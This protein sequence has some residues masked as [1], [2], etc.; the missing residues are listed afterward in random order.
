MQKVKEKGIPVVVIDRPMY[1][2]YL[3]LRWYRS[4]AGR[5]TVG[6]VYWSAFRGK[7]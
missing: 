1:G 5:K 7:R 4:M 2:D 6:R 3:G